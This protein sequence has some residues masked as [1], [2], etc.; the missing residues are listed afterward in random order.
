M[1]GG[2]G[3][4]SSSVRSAISRSGTASF[5]LTLPIDFSRSTPHGPTDRTCQDEYRK[6]SSDFRLVLEISK[7]PTASPYLLK[8]T[9]CERDSPPSRRIN[10]IE[11]D[12]NRMGKP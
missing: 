6:E 4:F 3:G 5:P 2:S 9:T 1:E 8:V 12:E 10:R 7:I 11:V